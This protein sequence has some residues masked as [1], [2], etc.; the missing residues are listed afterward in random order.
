MAGP[1]C[2]DRRADVAS[3]S[4]DRTIRTRIAAPSPLRA[5]N[6]PVDTFRAHFL[7]L[8]WVTDTEAAGEE[9]EQ[10]AMVEETEGAAVE[11]AEAEEDVWRAEEEDVEVRGQ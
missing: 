9:E 2:F 3:S 4:S 8:I 5:S 10:E 11:R 6:K 1:L 7:D